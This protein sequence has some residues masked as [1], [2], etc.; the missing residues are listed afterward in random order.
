MNFLAHLYLADDS[1]RSMIGNLLPD[2][3]RGPIRDVHDPV[4]LQAVERHRLVDRFTDAHPLFGRSK[5]RLGSEFGR[6][7]GIIVDILYDHLLTQHWGRYSEEPLEQFTTRFRRTMRDHAPLIPDSMSPRLRM[8]VEQD[9]LSAY[10]TMEGVEL[11]LHRISQ[12]LTRRLGRPIELTPAAQ[13]LIREREGFAED[14]NGFF[15][16]LVREVWEGEW[17][18]QVGR[19]SRPSSAALEV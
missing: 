9:W 19:A 15:P 13:A 4:I 17:D 5:R 2:F 8:M 1:P 11:T 10:C 6:F 7:S 14:F 12:R 16:E 3:V 18:G